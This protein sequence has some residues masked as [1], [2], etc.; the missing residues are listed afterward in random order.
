MSIFLEMNRYDTRI[1]G[2]IIGM[3]K[4]FEGQ[5]VNNNKP[6]IVVGLE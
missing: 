4:Y 5:K 1:E 2:D 6:H 3:R